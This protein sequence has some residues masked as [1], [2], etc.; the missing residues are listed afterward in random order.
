MIQVRL[1]CHWRIH[2]YRIATAKADDFRVT[3]MWAM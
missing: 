1:Q 2:D 3:A